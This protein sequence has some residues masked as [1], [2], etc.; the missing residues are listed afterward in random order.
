MRL[1]II[2]LMNSILSI[3]NLF[4]SYNSKSGEVVAI[5]G[6]NF[7]VM[8]GEFLSIIGSSGCGKSTI[9]NILSGLDKDY[10]GTY[11]YK[12]GVT[13]S[14]MLQ[15]D[16][17]FPWLTVLE[18]TLIGLKIQKKYTKENVEYV[19]HLLCKYGL[20]DFMNT[21]ISNLSGG[22]KQRVALIRS[23]ATK[24]NLIFLDEPFSAL[25][26][27]TRLRIS[28]DIYKIVKEENITVV[29]V[30]HNISESIS[31]SDRVLVLTRRPT[32]VKNIYEIKLT[33]KSTPINNRKAP[34]F[35]DYYDKLWKDIDE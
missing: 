16:A 10:E 2:L 17:L 15:E 20:E 8:E 35:Q 33:N 25:D 21:K 29:M 30:T 31:I 28:D 13:F 4:K 19:K 24:P 7:E 6:L 9:L 1:L 5:D 32:K 34:E 18:N 3:R 26:Y 12:E 27:Q 14:Y 11:E 23:I 22:M